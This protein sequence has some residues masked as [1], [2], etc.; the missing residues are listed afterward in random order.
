VDPA[1][2][3]TVRD[4][5][6]EAVA[7]FVDPRTGR[8]PVGRVWRREQVFKGRYA[9]E[10]PDL[11]LEPSP[12]YSLTHARSVVEP[13]DWLSGDHRL[14]GVLAA[15]GGQADPASFPDTARLVDLAPTILAAVGASA[16]VRHSGTVLPALVGGELAV[17]AN[18]AEP[19]SPP[20]LQEGLDDNEA[21]E[22]E[23]HLRGL[24]YLE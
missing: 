19:E 12:L 8:H 18:E 9:A 14:D 5:V 6:E 10:A 24:G 21:E 16:S 15:A 3:E 22:V 7:S 13:A 20:D 1:D 23:E 2:F 17:P 4:E 11:L